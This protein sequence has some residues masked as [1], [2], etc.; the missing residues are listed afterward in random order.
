M[1]WTFYNSDGQRLVK[2][3]SGG[4][5]LTGS[6]DNTITTVTGACAI[7]GEANLKF[8]GTYLT[9]GCVP[10]PDAYLHIR[11]T[12]ANMLNLTNTSSCGKIWGVQSRTCG[13]FQVNQESGGYS[14][15]TIS[16]DGEITS[17]KQP[18]FVAKLST[19]QENVA[20]GSGG[21]ALI[22]GRWANDQW[23]ILENRGTVFANG[24]FTAPVAGLYL[25]T[26]HVSLGGLT[27][28]NTYYNLWLD[29]DTAQG[30]IQMTSE[31]AWDGAYTVSGERLLRWSAIVEFDASDTA[32][33]S[34]HVY[35]GSQVVDIQTNTLFTA[36]LLG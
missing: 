25:V 28:S 5:S 19:T 31:S 36:F 22:D 12:G 23:N 18:G 27:S 29:T 30:N 17:P 14:V 16:P 10:T 34:G 24:T 15:I 8:N 7:Q 1:A 26:Y 11:N 33:L 35:Y 2:Q 4:V 32:Y 6:T 9:M 3:S 20:G 13:N 21:G